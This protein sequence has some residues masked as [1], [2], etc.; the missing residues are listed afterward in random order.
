MALPPS[1]AGAVQDTT[2]EALP[3]RAEA[4]VGPP[5]TVAGVTA[6]EGSDAAPVP[7]ALVA[8][9]VK[10][11][12]VPLVRP[13]TV[14]DVAPVV[15]QVLL[16]GDEVTVYPVMALPPSLAGA[17]HDTEAEA[18]PGVADT[19]V[20]APGAVG[21]PPVMLTVQRAGGDAYTGAG[22]PRPCLR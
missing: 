15:V 18:F 21:P 17:V 5:G 16:P 6:V 10:V 19:P 11:Y 13:L 9:T 8:V 2:A 14:Q 20:G 22:A 1:E 7:T 4:P 3:A 12:D